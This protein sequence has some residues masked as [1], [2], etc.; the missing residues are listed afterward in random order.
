MGLLSRM[1]RA[2]SG[3]ADGAAQGM[4][5]HSPLG[6]MALG[7]AVGAGVGAATNPGDP[8]QGAMAGGAIGAGALGAGPAMRTLGRGVSG[9]IAE[10]GMARQVAEQI[11]LRARGQP[12][13]VEAQVTQLR[14]QDPGLADE[15]M[16]ILMG[17]GR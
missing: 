6:N 13:L 10:A 3:F 2:A 5:S 4:Y 1:G 16:Q 7:G 8:L 11:M 17:G 12:G 15:V 9:A 14:M